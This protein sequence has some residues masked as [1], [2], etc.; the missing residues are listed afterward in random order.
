M[1]LV[2]PHNAQDVLDVCYDYNMRQARVKG[3]VLTRKERPGD[4]VAIQTE[5]G[6]KQGHLLSLDY[7]A[8]TK[9][10]ADVVILTDADGGD[11]T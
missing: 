11:T 7:S 6:I 5:D 4:Y 2:S 3:K 8:S 10:A 1:T 9:L